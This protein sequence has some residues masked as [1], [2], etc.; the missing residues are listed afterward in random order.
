MS[1]ILLAAFFL[2][3]SFLCCQTGGEQTFLVLNTNTSAKQ[4]AL[5]GKVLTFLDNVNQ[6]NLNPST[7]NSNI[8]RQLAVNY[9]S[10]IAGISIGSASYAHS[11]NKS[12]KTFYGSF[13]YINY[14]SLI[15]ADVFGNETGT[16]N[17]SDIA[18]TIGY[19]DKIPNTDFHWGANAKYINSSIAG[20]TATGIAADLGLIYYNNKHPYI[21]TLV[22]RNLGTQTSTFDGTNEDLPLDI[23]VG[24]SYR[25]EHVPLRLYGTFDNLQQWNIAV[26]N[27]SNSTTDLEGN[28]TQERID[29]FDNFIRHFSFGAELF[30]ESNINIRAG[31]N[32]RRAAELQ[33]QNVRTFGGISFGFGLKIKK[34]KVNYAF[35]KFHVATN[36]NTFSLEIDLSGNNSKTKEITKY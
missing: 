27:P 18:I 17:A 12:N 7:I 23:A 30:P 5:G 15:E 25:L 8:S 35:S 26:P 10:F 13:S 20:F 28:I 29:F 24:G 9:S 32:F 1:K 11:F 33:L 21:L 3:T 4:I 2:Y 14:G 31:Y 34:F 16:F 6:P 36:S 19:A 22:V